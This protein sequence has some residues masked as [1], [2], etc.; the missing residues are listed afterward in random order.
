MLA[1]DGAA[2]VNAMSLLVEF[3]DEKKIYF[4]DREICRMS[5]KWK[6]RQSYG[7]LL[8]HGFS[9]FSLAPL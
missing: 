5:E 9:R 4:V 7:V 1:A 2:I 6:L 8:H 3:V